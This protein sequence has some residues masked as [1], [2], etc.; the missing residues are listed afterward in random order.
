MNACQ[1]FY[2]YCLHEINM[3][4]QQHKQSILDGMFA[5]L[6][7]IFIEKFQLPF[8]SDSDTHSFVK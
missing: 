6:L 2:D 5:K 8:C 7:P 3:A 4:S 1:I